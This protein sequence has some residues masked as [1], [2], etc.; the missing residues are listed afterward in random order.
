[1]IWFDI[2]IIIV[3]LYSITKGYRS[4]IVKQ[5]TS[6][7]G[8]IIGAIIAGKIST[9]I[10]PYVKELTHISEP[11]LAS[12]SYIVAFALIII[13]FYIIGKML[14]SIIKAIKMNFLN[15]LLGSIFCIA[16]WYIAI[17][18]VLNLLIKLDTDKQLI[19]DSMIKKSYSFHY[20]QK[21]APTIIPYLQ[22]KL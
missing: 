4:G 6:L 13:F 2:F 16:K 5:F 8:L 12:V 10:Y 9:I 22:F 15:K 3:T 7:S 18:I 14:E 20:I 21:I 1:M 19:S 17:S 11:I